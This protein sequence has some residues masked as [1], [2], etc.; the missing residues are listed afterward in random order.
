MLTAVGDLNREHIEAYFSSVA[1][2]DERIDGR[3]PLSRS[4]AG[5]QVAGGERRDQLQS[6][7]THAAPKVEERPVSVINNAEL[8]ALIKTLA[9]TSFEDRR[10]T[11]IVLLSLNTGARLEETAQLQVGS[12]VFST[13]SC[14]CW[15]KAGLSRS[16]FTT[17]GVPL[18]AVGLGACLQ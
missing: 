15:A 5:V 1:R 16:R 7:R 9:S 14:T 4:P 17:G 13:A 12:S 8:S 10:D 2:A 6:F 11:A 3:H 18:V